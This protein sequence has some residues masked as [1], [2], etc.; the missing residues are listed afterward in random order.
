MP[1]IY[2]DTKGSGSHVGVWQ[3]TESWQTLLEMVT[4]TPE[5]VAKV[6]SFGRDSRKQEW[7]AARVLLQ[8]LSG[9]NPEIGYHRNG[10]PFL[11]NSTN[12]ISIS[13]TQGYAAVAISDANTVAID[14]EYPSPRVLKIAD[15]FLHPDEEAFLDK[16][17]LADYQTVIWCA[18]E[19]L[20]KWWGE[21]DV[22]FKEHLRIHPF[23]LQTDAVMLEATISKG[24]FYAKLALHCIVNSNYILV[25]I[26]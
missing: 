24:S 15:R 10:A 12:R 21:T 25:Y 2:R 14:I 18:K 17:R 26:L 4:L 7:L 13:H 6:T 11:Q 9:M 5:D 8:Q 23:T 20:F 16:Q 1:V 22:T 19:A 3:I